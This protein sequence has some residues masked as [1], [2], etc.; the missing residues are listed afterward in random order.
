MTATARV[1]DRH[2]VTH[3]HIGYPVVAGIHYTAWLVPRYDPGQSLLQSPFGRHPVGIHIAATDGRRTNPNRHLAVIGRGIRKLRNHDPSFTWKQESAHG[4]P[5]CSNGYKYLG[6]D[7]STGTSPRSD[8]AVHM[9]GASATTPDV[10]ST[11]EQI[12]AD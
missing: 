9:I 10:T 6:V 5:S 3:P 1:I 8:R 4:S 7:L 12:R 11:R 2:A